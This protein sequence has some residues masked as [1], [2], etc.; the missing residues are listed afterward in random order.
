MTNFGNEGPLNLR[1]PDIYFLRPISIILS[2]F[3]S[4]SRPATSIRGDGGFGYLQICR[5]KVIS[6]F[7]TEYSILRYKN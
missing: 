7:G 1:D 5:P 3:G 4:N 6:W 2:G